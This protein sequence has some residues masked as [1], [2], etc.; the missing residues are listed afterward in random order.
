VTPDQVFCEI[1]AGQFGL[2]ARDQALAT[3]LSARGIARRLASGRWLTV[4]PGVYAMAGAPDSWERRA[5][6]VQLWAG[7]EAALSH[8]SA[9]AVLGLRTRRPVRIDVTTPRRIRAASVTVHRSNLAASEKQRVGPFVVT[10]PLR[11]LVDL[12]AVMDE[13]RLEDCLEE[14]IFQR[15]TDVPSMLERLHNGLRGTRGATMLRQLI[16][17]RDPLWKPTE[18]DFETLLF[19]TLRKAGLP[20]PDRQHRVYENPS[21]VTRLDFAYP[22]ALLAVPADSYRWHGNRRGWE[23][24]IRVRNT[25][26]R[27]GW[28]MRPTTWTELKRTPDRFTHDIA[29]LL[30]RRELW[31]IEDEIRP[32][33][34]KGRQARSPPLK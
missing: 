10:S 30:E 26:L 7:A 18:S 33:I 25:L 15:L 12:A 16:E 23:N 27:M 6:A 32:Q 3:G 5:L 34:S 19:R 17:I 24:D 8:L 11:T 21:I 29:L 4:L 22:D 31:R 13:G 28:R 1:C 20:L 2:I 9:A 14:A